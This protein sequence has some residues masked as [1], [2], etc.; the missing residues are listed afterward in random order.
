MAAADDVPSGVALAILRYY[1]LHR[2]KLNTVELA[3]ELARL[4]DEDGKVRLDTDRSFDLRLRFAATIQLA[5]NHLLN[6][7]EVAGRFKA[8]PRFAQL[9]IDALD[10][11]SRA[12]EGEKATVALDRAAVV[13]CLLQRTADPGPGKPRIDGPH[14]DT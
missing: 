11:L 5:I 9:A 8:E 4:K 7:R 3:R 12:W 2:S 1:V 10:H 6:G 14:Q 13:G